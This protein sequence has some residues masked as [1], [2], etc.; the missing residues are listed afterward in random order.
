MSI[1]GSEN[2]RIGN[3]VY[4]AYKTWL[5]ALP[6]TGEVPCLLELQ[7]G[8]TIGHFNHIYATKKIILEKMY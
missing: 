2:I 4:V 1:D 5:A 7:D 3:R 8:V 6:H